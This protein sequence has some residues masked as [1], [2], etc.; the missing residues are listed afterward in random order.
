MIDVKQ[1]RELV[2][3]PTLEHLDLW[4]EAAENLLVGTAVQESRLEFLQQHGG[5]PALGV[6]Q[7]EPA[8][9]L[10]VWENFLRYRK[11]PSDNYLWNAV[12]N[13]AAPLPELPADE[14]LITNLAYATAIARIIYYRRPEPLPA[15]DDIEGLAAY[16][17]QHYNTP[18]GKGDPDEWADNYR[19]YAV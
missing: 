11:G 10:D 6:Y 14:Q 19:R 2:V 13:L 17:K 16:W 8:T 9:H 4:S 1:F 15:A 12:G 3:R 5:G 7:I 18:L